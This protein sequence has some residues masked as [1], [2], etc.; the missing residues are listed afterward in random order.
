MVTV[1]GRSFA[2][3]GI[4]EATLTGP[5]SFVFMPY[6]RAQ[7]LLIESE[8]LLRRLV[9]VPGSKLLPIATAAAVFWAEN[10]DPAEVAERIRKAVENVSVV[11]PADA[12]EQIDRALIVLNGVILGAG[13]VALLVASLAVTNTMFTAIVERRREI[14]LRRVVGATRR[15]V[16]GQLLVESALLGLGGSLLGL[17]AGALAV[18]GVNGVTERLGAPVFLLTPRLALA[19]GALPAGLAALAGVWPAWRAARMPPTE[20]VRYA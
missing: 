16:V 18:G 6:A 5:D 17:A 20:A 7:T 3:V 4:L 12:A 9:M 2:V 10:E 15:Q 13:L 1:R 8:P 11:A 19:A 14:G